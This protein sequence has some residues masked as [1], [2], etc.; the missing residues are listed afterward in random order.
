MGMFENETGLQPHRRKAVNPVK[1][2]I[3]PP[4]MKKRVLSFDK[5]PGPRSQ[6]KIKKKQAINK[7]FLTSRTNVTRGEIAASCL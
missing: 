6:F 5:G 1:R 2:R 3:I 7:R 4:I